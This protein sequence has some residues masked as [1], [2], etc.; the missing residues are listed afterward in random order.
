MARSPV[1][2]YQLDDAAATRV[3]FRKCLAY[4]MFTDFQSVCADHAALHERLENFPLLEYAA[5]NW[6]S[7][8]GEMAPTTFTLTIA[9][10][11]TIL[12][13]FGIRK[14]KGGGNFTAWT[15]CLLHEAPVELAETTEPL[16]YAASYGLLPVVERLL[17]DGA[18]IDA[19]GGRA[20]STALQ[21]AC[22]RDQ[23]A[24]VE[25]LLRAG[26]CPDS[27]SK[28]GFS[29]LY[30]ARMRGL[31]H[32]GELLVQY[33]ATDSRMPSSPTDVGDFEERYYYWVCSQCLNRNIFALCPERCTS[34]NHRL[35]A[36]CFPYG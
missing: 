32:I 11:E 9:E 30:C 17:Q 22:Y 29:N 23:P 26:A 31:P 33:G 7:H 24:I 12:V 25:V 4:L 20:S 35:C 27:K 13:F 1:A 14:L 28:A 18:N 3:I 5:Q 21:V 19:R 2:F 34:C 6:A 10:I 15:Q 36:H 8:A 16:Y